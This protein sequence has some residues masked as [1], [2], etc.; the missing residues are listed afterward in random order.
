MALNG[1]ESARY[2][3]VINSRV[4]E[5]VNQFIFW[6]MDCLMDYR[7]NRLTAY[8]LARFNQTKGTILRRLKIN[9]GRIP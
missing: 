3:T 5:K 4:A 7:R 2:E 1:C 9:S 6:I 8:I